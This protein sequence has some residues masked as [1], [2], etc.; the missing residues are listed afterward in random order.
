MLEE[1]KEWQDGLGAIVG[2]IGLIVV[3][4]VTLWDARRRERNAKHQQSLSVAV[5]IYGEIL[6]LREKLASLGKAASRLYIRHGLQGGDNFDSHFVDR[7]NLPDPQL[8]PALASKVGELPADL[9]REI[10]RF[11]S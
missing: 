3:T 6:L 1:I 5:A 7:F 8:Y 11:Y 4:Q 9:V 10:T 2:F